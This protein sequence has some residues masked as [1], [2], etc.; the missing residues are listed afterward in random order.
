MGETTIWPIVIPLHEGGGVE[1]NN[2][3]LRYVLRGYEKHLKSP[4]QIVIIGRKLPDWARGIRLIPQTK[5]RLKSALCMAAAAFPDGFFWAYDDTVPV[6][7]TTAE[8]MQI[9][10]A[11]ERFGTGGGTSWTS[12]LNKIRDRLLAEGHEPRDY[13]RPHCPYWFDK[14]M[15]DEGFADWPG[16][17][18]KF[19]WE[20]W[21]LSKRKWPFRTGVEK[22]YY[23]RFHS[24]PAEHHAFVNFANGGWTPELKQWLAGQFPEPCRFEKE[25]ASSPSSWMVATLRYGE[26]WWVG[27]CGGTLDAWCLQHGHS[28]RVWT[29]AEIPR[30][31][32]HPKFVQVDMLREFLQSDHAWLLYVDA[33]VYVS[34]DAASA[35]PVDPGAGFYIKPDRPCGVSRSFG[36]WC[37]E[38]FGADARKITPGWNYRNAGVWCCDRES[39]RRMLE[40]ITEPYHQK[41]ME[42]HHWNWWICAAHAKGMPVWDLPQGWNVWPSEPGQ[43]S[44][45]HI[46]GKRKAGKLH[47][48]REDGR[49]PREDSIKLEFMNTFDFEKYRFAHVGNVMP[50]DILH[51]HA[52]HAA[53]LLVTGGVAVEIGSYMGA[54]TAALVEAVNLGILAHLHVIEVKP[55][56]SLRRVL[57][58]CDFPDRVTLHVKPSWEIDLKRAD[59]VF[60][61]GDHG[62]ACLIDLL[63][64]LAWDARVVAMHDTRTWPRF[65]STWGSH[66]A[67]NAMRKMPGW[68]HVED[69]KTRPGMATDR[70][71]MVAAREGTD[72]SA[73]RAVWK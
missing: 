32:P 5:G 12:S 51:I 61:D 54:S 23:G 49:I 40:V 8:E 15:V 58:L 14:G 21:I 34:P 28:L 70:G 73:V 46:V 31:Y 45:Y 64:T 62:A 17:A 6:R 72:L 53:C 38:K 68:H 1:G 22:Q 26:A 11:R 42:Q 59:L 30:N 4:H 24:A 48:L 52:L 44:F 16:M 47:A 10:V 20:S 18:G 57:A 27:L 9:T 56:D 2:A 71:F 55:T 3:E 63:T 43:G 66:H 39:A 33:D 69:A 60:I 19:P 35:P 65:N 36:R 67:A 7:D 37:S 29:E 13:S 50:M 41:I 25:K